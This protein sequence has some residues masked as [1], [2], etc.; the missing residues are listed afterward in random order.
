MTVFIRLIFAVTSL[1]IAVQIPTKKFLMPVQIVVK[2]FLIALRTVLTKFFIPFQ[3]LTKKFLMLVQ[4]FTQNS[5]TSPRSVPKIPQIIFSAFFSVSLMK[6]HTAEKIPLMPSHTLLQ[7]PVKMPTKISRILRIMSV[8]ALKVFAICWN[9]PSKIGF[10]NLQSPSH[11][12]L[13]TSVIF[14]KSNPSALMR[15]TMP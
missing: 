4:T 8:T 3:M 7:S 11:T 5:F 14:L 15:S 10:R 2:K 12:A 13:M 6:F 9:C 1:Y